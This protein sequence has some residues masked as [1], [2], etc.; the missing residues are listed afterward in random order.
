MAHISGSHLHNIAHA[1]K[2]HMCQNFM[3][4]FLKDN[5]DDQSTN[6]HE[7]RAKLSWNCHIVQYRH[8]HHR[9]IFLPIYISWGFNYSTNQLSPCVSLLYSN[10]HNTKSQTKKCV[11]ELVKI[12]LMYMPS[13]DI[14]VGV[15]YRVYSYLVMGFT[16]TKMLCIS[17]SCWVGWEQKIY[18]NLAADVQ[19]ICC[20]GSDRI[21]HR[22]YL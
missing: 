13:L 22:V 5:Y 15:H 18:L 12:W 1:V 6:A 4:L 21:F 9:F 7:R 14:N 2:L 8:H 10:M 11:W 19:L 20:P 17:Q 16:V 3:V